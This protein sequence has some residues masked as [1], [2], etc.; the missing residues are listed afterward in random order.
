MGRHMKGK[1]QVFMSRTG[2]YPVDAIH[3]LDGYCAGDAPFERV[4]QTMK[5]STN[6]GLIHIEKWSP[7]MEFPVDVVLVN[8]DRTGALVESLIE[9]V[10]VNAPKPRGRPRKTLLSV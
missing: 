8:G 5:S 2:I 6:T 10:P 1:T 9:Q 3:L 4:A 7:G